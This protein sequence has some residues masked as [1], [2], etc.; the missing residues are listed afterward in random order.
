MK[1]GPKK[2]IPLKYGTPFHDN[3]LIYRIISAFNNKKVRTDVN[4][5]PYNFAS[6]PDFVNVILDGAEQKKCLLSTNC[7]IDRHVR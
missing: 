7:D 3:V 6:F 4:D 5:R 1:G 2:I